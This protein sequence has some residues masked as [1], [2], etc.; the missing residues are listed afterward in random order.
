[1]TRFEA[2]DQHSKH[3]RDHWEEDLREMRQSCPIV[4]SSSYGGFYVLSRY[5][6]PR[7]LRWYAADSSVLRIARKRFISAACVRSP[8]R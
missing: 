5:R 1:M 3:H 4:K 8:S 7:W 6:L 2:F